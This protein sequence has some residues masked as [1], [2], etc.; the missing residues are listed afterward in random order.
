MAILININ[1]NISSRKILRKFW[2]QKIK[3]KDLL[4]FKL[5]PYKTIR[6]EAFNKLMN[7]ISLYLQD[8]IIL[9][10]W[11]L[12]ILADKEVNEDIRQICVKYLKGKNINVILYNPWRYLMEMLW[13]Y[14][15]W[16]YEINSIYELNRILHKFI[17]NG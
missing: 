17:K 15:I 1:S 3:W 7:N 10:W 11:Y 16:Y 12:S 6:W 14:N 2:E 13:K 4:C 8:N 9:I 5:W